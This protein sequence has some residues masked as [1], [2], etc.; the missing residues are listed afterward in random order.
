MLATLN[1]SNNF[2]KPRLCRLIIFFWWAINIDETWKGTILPAHF[3]TT[4]MS[5]WRSLNDCLWLILVPWTYAS[6]SKSYQQL[7]LKELQETRTYLRW[8][9]KL[10]KKKFLKENEMKIAKEE[11]R[12]QQT[13][14]NISIKKKKITVS[15]PLST[16]NIQTV[17]IAFYTL[18]A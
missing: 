13:K 6:K 7:L 12:S 2:S 14:L 3:I 17:L 4:Q 11:I 18:K 8:S 16:W 1:V 10:C 9:L 5:W 15:F